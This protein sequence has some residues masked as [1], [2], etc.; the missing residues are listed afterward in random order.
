MNRYILNVFLSFNS[1]M[2]VQEQK[3]PFIFSRNRQY[4][5]HFPFFFPVYCECFKRLDL[6]ALKL[7]A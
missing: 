4:A 7:L 5:R 3:L 1:R 2:Q 6:I